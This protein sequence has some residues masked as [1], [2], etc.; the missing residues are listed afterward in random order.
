VLL[1]AWEV[2]KLDVTKVTLEA[3]AREA[4][5]RSA[6]TQVPEKV[7]KAQYNLLHSLQPF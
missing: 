1:K 7:R 4:I 3:F 6:E 2:E 5:V